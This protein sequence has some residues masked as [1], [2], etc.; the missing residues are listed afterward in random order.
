MAPLSLLRRAPKMRYP[1]NHFFRNGWQSA[2]EIPQPVLW[3]NEHDAFWTNDREI[4]NPS[5]GGS[6]WI[7][8]QGRE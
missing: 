2:A 3:T 6:K 8:G 1:E 5:Y 7:P 4:Q